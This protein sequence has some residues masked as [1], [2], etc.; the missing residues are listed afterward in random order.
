MRQKP[1][2]IANKVFLTKSAYQAY[3]KR[4]DGMMTTGAKQTTFYD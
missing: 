2:N 4:H 1:F 3:I